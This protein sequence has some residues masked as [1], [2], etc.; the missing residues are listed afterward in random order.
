MT[1]HVEKNASMAL[2]SATLL[3]AG[4]VDMSPACHCRRTRGRTG[5]RGFD[6]LTAV[7]SRPVDDWHSV[8]VHD[9]STGGMPDI[10]CD[11]TAALRARRT[12]ERLAARWTSQS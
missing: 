9:G 7:N 6:M 12:T 2:T 11:S 1:R 5:G 3:E 8:P 4:T 10:H